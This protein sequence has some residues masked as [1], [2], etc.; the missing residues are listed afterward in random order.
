MPFETG[1]GLGILPFD[2]GKV[3]AGCCCEATAGGATPTA[4]NGDASTPGGTRVLSTWKL[5]AVVFASV[6]GTLRLASILT[7]GRL[8]SFDRPVWGAGDAAVLPLDPPTWMVIFLEPRTGVS[9]P[10]VIFNLILGCGGSCTA[11]FAWLSSSAKHFCKDQ[12]QF[13]RPC[14]RP[15]T[16]GIIP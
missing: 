16:D 2:S 11:A 7:S 8:E 9:W 13:C 3:A 12:G 4:G 14:D 5:A 10:G 6:G 1:I 15:M